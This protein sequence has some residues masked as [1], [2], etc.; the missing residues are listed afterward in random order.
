MEELLTK[1]QRG[2]KEYLLEVGAPNRS[3]L[4]AGVSLEMC[5][6]YRQ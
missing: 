2:T 1:Q 5:R 3:A 4:C 6:Q